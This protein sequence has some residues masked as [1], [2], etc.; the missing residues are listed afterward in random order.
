M[1]ENPRSPQNM[2][3]G[4]SPGRGPSAATGVA[5]SHAPESRPS[6]NEARLDA[7]VSSIDQIVF[8]LDGEGT[9]LNVW[10]A[11]ESLLYRPRQELLRRKSREFFPEEQFAPFREIYRRV[12][13]TG[14][15]EDV[16]YELEVAAGRRWFLARVNR[17]P[18]SDGLRKSVCMVI[19][20]ITDRKHAEEKFAKAFLCSPEAMVISGIEDGRLIDFNE[21]FLRLSGFTRAELTGRSSDEMGFWV[22]PKERLQFAAQLRRQGEVQEIEMRF[23]NKSGDQRI[24]QISAHTIDL[25]RV[26]CFIA[27]LRD[28]TERKALEQQL[29]E[30]QKM[31]AV[32]RLA[33]GVAHDFNNLLV[34]ILGYSELLQKKLPRG[35]ELERMAE[36]IQSAAMRARDLTSRLLALSRRQVLHPRVIDFNALVQQSARLLGPTLA[37]DIRLALRLDPKT[38]NVKAD[39]AQLEQVVLNLAINA[40]DAMPRGGTLSIESCNIQVDAALARRHAGLLPGSYVRLWVADTGCGMTP[41]VM[42]RI[43]EPFFST[44]APEKGSGLGL[45]TVY[46]IVKQTGGCVTVA[47]EPGRGAA[48]GIYLP[49]AMEPLEPPARPAPLIEGRRGLETVLLVEDEPIVRRLTSALLVEG[50]Y[51]TLCAPGGAEALQLLAE[52]SEAIHLLITDVV[53]PEMS[54]P[55]LASRLCKIRPHTRVLYMSG[56]TDDETLG[57]R[58]LPGNSAFLQK[59]FT[60]PEFIRKVRETL[61]ATPPPRQQQRS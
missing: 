19:R 12:L 41:D 44:K 28:I 21:S 29:R 2:A 52:N 39:P 33:G 55:E 36:E 20:D 26:D 48:F 45:S 51:R 25:G 5:A 4:S 34:G 6:E 24:L 9:F 3:P 7:L 1:N 58:G 54:G 56:Y 15:G 13:E 53:M 60:P 37:E 18:S 61:D 42:A 27:T 47:S 49:R 50:G 35:G 10:A 38:G 16:E 40:R 59:P 30:V 23:V 43:F 22:N 46:G 17:I 32:G 8:E 14:R 11:N 31:E 57:R